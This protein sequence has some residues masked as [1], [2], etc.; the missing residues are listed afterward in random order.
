MWITALFPFIMLANSPPEL[1]LVLNGYS[2]YSSVSNQR[3][4]TGQ[5][6]LLMKKDHLLDSWKN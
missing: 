2:K 3:G 1:P 4:Q 6:V 5:T